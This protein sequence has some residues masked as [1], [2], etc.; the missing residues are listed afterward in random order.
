MNPEERYHR[1]PHFRTL[2]DVLTQ[3]IIECNYS[4]TELRE[5]VMLAA[6]HY[7]QM[8][9]YLP[10][11]IDPVTREVRRVDSRYDKEKP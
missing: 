4:P 3:Q 10:Y 1:D 6:I 11:S 5:A 8:S 9:A 7:D 2:V